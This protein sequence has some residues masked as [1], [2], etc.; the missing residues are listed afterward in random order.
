MYTI[1]KNRIA[2]V[3]VILMAIVFVGCAPEKTAQDKQRELQNTIVEEGVSKVGL[4]GIKNFYEAKTMKAI[5]ELCDDG[6]VTYT[7]I[8][9]MIPTPTPGKTAMG[10]K[11]TY[12][13]ATIGYPIPYSTQFT[14]PEAM[15]TFNIDGRGSSQRYYGAER[16]PQADPN[17]L[18][19]PASAEATWV[20]MK[21]PTTDKVAPVYMEPKLACFPFK[22]PL[23]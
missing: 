15:Q 4:P 10:G 6:I 22:L 8:E 14:S 20:L 19:K 17:G 1:S 5:Q 11:F 23:D 7:Y 2:F 3:I 16:L 9:N 13:G 21:D 18:Y 12:L